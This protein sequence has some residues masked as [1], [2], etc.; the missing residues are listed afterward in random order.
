MK[1]Q[2]I[3]AVIGSAGLIVVALINNG[4]GLLKSR[5]TIVVRQ[6]NEVRRRMDLADTILSAVLDQWDAV[7]TATQNDRNAEYEKFR[8]YCNLEVGLLPFVWRGY[9]DLSMFPG[10]RDIA[11]GKDSFNN[12][13]LD[14]IASDYLK[15]RYGTSADT[16]AQWQAYKAV[17]SRLT[18]AQT[19]FALV[20]PQKGIDEGTL[21]VSAAEHQLQQQRAMQKLEDCRVALSQIKESLTELRS[22][23]PILSLLRV[24]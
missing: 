1:P 15:A 9:S 18:A 7:K 16:S 3:A 23:E 19:R 24:K 8:L 2:I 4:F 21:N 6:E 14:Q 10:L 5:Q 12:Y 20:L 22:C 11:Q 13:A 17:L